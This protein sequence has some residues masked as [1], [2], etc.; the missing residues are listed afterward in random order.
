MDK[1]KGGKFNYNYT[2]NLDVVIP[3]MKLPCTLPRYNKFA[4]AL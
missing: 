3:E 2:E 1:L 4:S